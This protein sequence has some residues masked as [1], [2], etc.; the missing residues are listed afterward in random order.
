M[1]EMLDTRGLAGRQ[2]QIR[3][4]QIC[5]FLLTM[6]R[7]LRTACEPSANCYPGISYPTRMAW[8][9]SA[10][11]VSVPSPARIS[12]TSASREACQENTAWM[13]AVPAASTWA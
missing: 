8:I 5:P 9:A 3:F 4:A 12:A 2:G 13:C 1:A 11:S 6:V 7:I 10:F